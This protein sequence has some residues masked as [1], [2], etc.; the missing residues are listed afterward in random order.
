V[1]PV[2]ET[3]QYMGWKLIRLDVGRT[4]L[5]CRLK[6]RY[7]WK[8]PA[9]AIHHPPAGVRDFPMLRRVLTGIKARAEH[10][11]AAARSRQGW[12]ARHI[13]VGFHNLVTVCD[14]QRHGWTDGRHAAR[15]YSWISP[16]KTS[17]TVSS[18]EA[19][20]AGSSG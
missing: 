6:Q 20:P 7:A 3:G 2:G 10:S 17:A 4:R 15:P 13:R 18:P 14:L 12:M 11:T 19:R 16:P 1:A 8:K 5:I 9:S